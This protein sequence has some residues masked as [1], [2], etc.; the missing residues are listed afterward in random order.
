[1]ASKQQEEKEG[2][3]PARKGRWSLQQPATNQQRLWPRRKQTTKEAEDQSKGQP[4]RRE[5]KTVAST[6]PVVQETT[7]MVLQRTIS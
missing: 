6:R 2:G 7:A 3:L 4:R 5:K 1:M